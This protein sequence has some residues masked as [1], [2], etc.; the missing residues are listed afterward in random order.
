MDKK[1]I[2]D[3]NLEKVT[4][5]LDT[6]FYGDIPMCPTCGQRNIKMISSDEYVDTYKCQLCGMVSIH[7]KKEKPAPVPIHPELQ[8]P[9][10]GSIGTWNLLRSDNGV[11]YLECTVCRNKLAVVPGK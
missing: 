1:D 10:C 4:G 8:C 2:T 5:G 9:I 11:D 3:S 7:T 6:I